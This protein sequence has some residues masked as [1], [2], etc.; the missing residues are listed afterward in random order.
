MK[1]ILLTILFT[2]YLMGGIFMIYGFKN[3]KCK[4]Q[5]FTTLDITAQVTWEE[6]FLKRVPYPEGFT[7]DNTMFIGS[8]YRKTTGTG[9]QLAWHHNSYTRDIM[10]DFYSDCIQVFG[11][12][13]GAQETVEIVFR[14]ILLKTS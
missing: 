2:A 13:W 7:K 3:N 11:D 4:Q 9:E 1:K 5:I 6:P 12:N 8:A 14:L 10:V